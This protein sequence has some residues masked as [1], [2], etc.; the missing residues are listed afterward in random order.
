MVILGHGKDNK[1][2]HI[3]ILDS[4]MQYIEYDIEIRHDYLTPFVGVRLRSLF[5]PYYLSHESEVI[6]ENTFNLQHPFYLYMSFIKQH[7]DFNLRTTTA[8]K[9]L[10]RVAA[11]YNIPLVKDWANTTPCNINKIWR[12]LLKNGKCPWVNKEYD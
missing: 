1:F 10:G 11:Y 8:D 6:F 4:K 2:L 3:A 12:R 9:M 5:L 7:V